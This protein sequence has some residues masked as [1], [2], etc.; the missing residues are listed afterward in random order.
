MS[1]AIF[2]DIIPAVRIE[3]ILFVL[4]R[5]WSINPVD[6]IPKRLPK[7][8]VAGIYIEHVRHSNEKHRYP[9]RNT[10]HPRK[11]EADDS[12]IHDEYYFKTASRES[13]SSTIP[14]RRGPPGTEYMV[15][16]L[17]DEN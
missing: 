3:C 17:Y 9:S 5:L 12:T 7:R 4:K 10:Q 6:A 16:D 1:K 15:I 2:I 8:Y 11:W 14:L 13:F